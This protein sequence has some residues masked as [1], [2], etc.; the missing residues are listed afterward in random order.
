MAKGCI[1]QT[2]GLSFGNRR[3]LRRHACPKKSIP[4]LMTI[5]CGPP[6]GDDDWQ[7]EPLCSI[8]PPPPS[9]APPAADAPR[10]SVADLVPPTANDPSADGSGTPVLPWTPEPTSPP[11][12]PTTPPPKGAARA[13]TPDYQPA[14]P[15]EFFT[16]PELARDR[17]RATR[18]GRPYDELI[19]VPREGDTAERDLTGTERHYASILGPQR[20]RRMCDCRRCVAHALESFCT[21]PVAPKPVIPGIRFARLPGITVAAALREEMKRLEAIVADQPSLALVACGCIPCTAHR[22]LL[23][24][25][26]QARETEPPASEDHPPA[27][28]SCRDS[29]FVATEE[30]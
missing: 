6:P 21:A 5:S 11:E 27:V 23:K 13:P 15:R 9:A 3:A 2:C 1:C 12:P 17:G 16:L 26:T 8:E 18:L 7:N 19:V 4:R 25:W 30:A 24:A 10:C 20:Q 29:R 28:E 14:S 22:N